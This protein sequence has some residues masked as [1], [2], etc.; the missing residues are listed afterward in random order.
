M[1]DANPWIDVTVPVHGAMPTWPGDPPVVLERERS[2]DRGDGSNVTRLALGAHTGTHVDAPL[3]F[4]AAGTPVDRMPLDATMGPARVIGIRDGAA[5]GR[6]A[7][8]RED[9]REG[10]RIL[11]RTANSDRP[12]FREPFRP[13]FVA[14]APD[15]A[16][17][18]AQRRIRCLGVDY[19]SVGPYDAEAENAQTH[20]LLLAA[21]V[22][23]VEGLDLSAVKPGAY[24]LL[25][26]PLRLEGA[27]GAPAR[28]LLRPIR[29]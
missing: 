27:E 11:L 6:A 4:L 28:A 20:R 7:L 9:V 16:E 2:L 10:E 23:I 3:H 25:C 14:L 8:V 26:L 15:A 29:S 22:W 19:L 13:R 17:Y 24:E 5:I 21:G 18:L 12:W 1:P